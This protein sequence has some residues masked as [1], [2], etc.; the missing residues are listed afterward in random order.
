MAC[1][2]PLI[3][4]YIYIHY[5]VFFRRVHGV[6]LAHVCFLIYNM[7][8]YTSC[9]LLTVLKSV[10][11]SWLRGGGG[12]STWPRLDGPVWKSWAKLHRIRPICRLVA[13]WEYVTQIWT[14]SGSTSPQCGKRH[15]ASQRS[16]AVM[17]PNSFQRA[18]WWGKGWRPSR[19]MA[20]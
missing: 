15:Q 9:T 11:N 17:M 3:Y 14:P 10:V 5:P 7:Y 20:M 1:F 16:V 6:K 2:L 18:V 19:R 12:P 8:M 4:I 13:T